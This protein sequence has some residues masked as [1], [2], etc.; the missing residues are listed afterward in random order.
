MRTKINVALYITLWM[1]LIHSIQFTRCSETKTIKPKIVGLIA[2]HNEAEIIKQ[3]LT[4]MAVYTDAIVV[5]DD[6]SQDNTLEIVESLVSQCHIEKIIKKTVWMRDELGDK[7]ALLFAGRSI[8]GTHFIML[9]ADEI[10]VAPCS[11]KNWLRKHILKLERGQGMTFAMVHVWGNLHV[12]RDDELCNPMMSRWKAVPCVFYDD[13]ICNYND[14]K[15]HGTSGIM[16]VARIPANIQCLDPIKII[17]VKDLDHSLIH[18]KYVNLEDIETKKIWYMCLEYIHANKNTPEDDKKK[19]AARINEYYNK[20]IQFALA[21]PAHINLKPIPSR[22]Y[23]YPFFDQ[24]IYAQ[25]HTYK[26]NEVIS[27]LKQYGLPYFS[28]LE[29]THIPWIKSAA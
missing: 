22:W 11:Y 8:G 6:A 26:K 23:D 25:L 20:K 14:N 1:L 15:I 16:H 5:L 21:D 17:K 7:N 18:F 10:F 24:S 28:Y 12:Y 29:I 4:T 19:N 13:G 9:D 2:V 27:W 3:C